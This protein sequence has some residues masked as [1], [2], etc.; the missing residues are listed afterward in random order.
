MPISLVSSPA[1]YVIV[2]SLARLSILAFG[3]CS[4]R[5]LYEF[6]MSLLLLLLFLLGV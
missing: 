2:L 5:V 4:Y 3:F 1:I 6:F